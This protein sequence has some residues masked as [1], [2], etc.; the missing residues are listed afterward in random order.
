MQRLAVVYRIVN[1]PDEGRWR[2]RLE[3]VPEPYG[4]AGGQVLW[5]FDQDTEEAADTIAASWVKDGID[6]RVN[7]AIR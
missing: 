5:G 4:W 7:E 1:G 6:P 3:I 2:I